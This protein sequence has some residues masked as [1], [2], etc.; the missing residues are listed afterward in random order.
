MKIQVDNPLLSLPLSLPLLCNLNALSVPAD[1]P[2]PPQYA[3]LLIGV[4]EVRSKDTPPTSPPEAIRYT[5]AF[6][7]SGFMRVPIKVE[8]RVPSITPEALAAHGPVKVVIEGYTSGSFLTDDGGARPYFRAQ[9]I[10]PAP[11]N[12]P[13]K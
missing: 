11:D 12:V 3:P 8:E 2:I 5:L 13:S 1:G 6:P 7:G 10:T 4:E 9:K